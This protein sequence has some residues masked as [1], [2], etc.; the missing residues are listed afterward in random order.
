MRIV[1]GEPRCD[2]DGLTYVVTTCG[3]AMEDV[4]VRRHCL[5]VRNFPIQKVPETWFTPP[6]WINPA[7]RCRCHGRSGLSWKNACG[8][9]CGSRMGRAWL[10]CAASSVSLG[11][12]D[13]KSMNGT[14]S[15]G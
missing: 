8:L 3:Y 6:G 4:E 7:R 14:K 1:V 9:C 11:L 15:A 2:I 12:P 10:R 13:T 5:S